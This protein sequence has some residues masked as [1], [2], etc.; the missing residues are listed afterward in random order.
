MEENGVETQ[1]GRRVKTLRSDNGGE[2]TTNPFFEVYQDEGI[3]RHFTVRKTPQQNGVAE[4]MNRILV[5]K[6]RCMLSYSG[7]SKVFWGEA[8]SYARHIVNRL[9]S[10]ALDGRTP[11]E[12]WSGSPANDYDSMRIFGYMIIICRRAWPYLQGIEISC[13]GRDL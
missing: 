9:P 11:L 1:T 5:E 8:L 7:L 3:K 2:Y 10:A 13:Q 12:V 4:R 6:V